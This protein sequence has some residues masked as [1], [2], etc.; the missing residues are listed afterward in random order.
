MTE[1]RF[2]DLQSSASSDQFCENGLLLNDFYLPVELIQ[3]IL[4]F[5]DEKSLLSCQLVC[6]HWNDIIMDYVWRRKAEIST[7]CKFTSDSVL[8]WKDF[9]LISAKQIFQRNLIKKS[10]G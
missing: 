10:F 4:C 6:K 5:A 2:F 9:Y 3:R 1:D 7:G 8:G